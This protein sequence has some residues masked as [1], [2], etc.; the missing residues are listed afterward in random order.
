M[1]A[2]EESLSQEW[3][4]L[5]HEDCIPEPTSSNPPQNEDAEFTEDET[6]NPK[7]GQYPRI[8]RPFELMRNS[9]DVVIIGY[10]CFHNKFSFP[11]EH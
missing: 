8:S 3:V 6:Y 4:S 5:D 1:K 2:D 10:V 11:N 7:P 9:Y